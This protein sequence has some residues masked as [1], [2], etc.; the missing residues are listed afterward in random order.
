VGPVEPL[1]RDA[2]ARPA[3]AAR[4]GVIACL[5]AGAIW[6]GI[7]VGPRMLPQFDAPTFSLARD[8]CFGALSCAL[9]AWTYARRAAASPPASPRGPLARADLAM[10]SW[11]GLVGNLLYFIALVS[12]IQRTGI[13]YASLIVGLLP[14]TTTLAADWV[15]RRSA[16][17]AFDAHRL[18]PPL[19]VIA[20]GVAAVNADLFLRDGGTGTQPQSTGD[21]LLGIVS[22]FLALAAWT[23]YAV[24]NTRYLRAHPR[25]GV[26]EWATL[27]GVGTLFWV[28]V[29]WLAWSALAA[30]DHAE[31]PRL[32][33]ALAQPAFLGWILFL[34]LGASWLGTALWNLGSRA[35]APTLSGQMIVFETVFGL[36]YGFLFEMRLPHALEAI[37]IVL[38]L[39]G[40]VWA[41]RAHG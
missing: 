4:T 13:A 31:P 7:F 2:A 39:A 9:L 24:Q 1:A 3:A 38:L 30:G 27:Q 32:A 33:A 6:G 35:L 26:K 28:A 20:A 21:L 10:A 37:G 17:R 40:V 23:V 19:A 22:A 11:L 41:V 12:A 25:I 29:A 14:V 34:G 15:E 18:L 16:A 8:L 36:L 5:A